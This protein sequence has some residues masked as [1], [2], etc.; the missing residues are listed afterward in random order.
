M[1]AACAILVL[2]L[3]GCSTGTGAKWYAPATWFSGAPAG[4]VD[5]AEQ[6]EDK[7]RD[8]VIKAAQKATHETGIALAAAPSSRPVQVAANSNNEATALLDQAAGP[9][10]AEEV[11]KLRATVAGLLSEIAS[12]RE[13][14]E[15]QKADES[16]QIAEVSSALAKAEQA[17]ADAAGKLRAA[18]ERENALANELRS[19]RALFWIACGVAVVVAAGWIYVRFAL[20]GF[21]VAVGRALGDIR[22]RNPKL[23]EEIT[24]FL[25]GY[26]NRNE[27]ALIAKN[28]R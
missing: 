1:R 12:V 2:L 16:K 15:K 24:P 9:L 17:S 26:L 13:K 10:T 23:A 11:A 20:G 6:K 19:Q 7:A 22:Q 3:S 18:F 5:R 4:A 25:D 14:A 27:Q 21:P 8:R 28:A